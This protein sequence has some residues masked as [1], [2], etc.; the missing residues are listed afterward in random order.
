MNNYYNDAF[1]R[2]KD[3]DKLKNNNLFNWF[4]KRNF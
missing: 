1:A 2:V 3:V 4:L